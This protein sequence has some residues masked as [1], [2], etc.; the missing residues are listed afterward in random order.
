M[1]CAEWQ[2]HKPG[3]KLFAQGQAAESVMLVLQGSVTM[4]VDEAGHK[5]YCDFAKEEMQACTWI[6][7]VEFMDKHDDEQNRMHRASSSLDASGAV[8]TSWLTCV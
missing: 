4:T 2:E 5:F 7:E 1:E 3:L 8:R 6:G